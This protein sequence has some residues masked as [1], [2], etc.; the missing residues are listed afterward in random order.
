MGKTVLISVFKLKQGEGGRDI[1]QIIFIRGSYCYITKTVKFLGNFFIVCMLVILSTTTAP[2]T[3]QIAL[4]AENHNP[5]N[6]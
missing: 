4:S 3:G 2:V 5:R 6:I 1:I